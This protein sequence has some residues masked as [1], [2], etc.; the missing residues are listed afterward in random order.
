MFSRLIVFCALTA[1]LL[2]AADFEATYTE[3]G[4][5]SNTSRVRIKDGDVVMGDQ[6]ATL[7]YRSDTKDIVAIDHGQ[8][9]YLVFDEAT[10]ERM[11]QQMGDMQQ[12]M[13]AAMQQ[14][15]SQMSQMSEE[16]RAMMER[17][18]EQQ[19]MGAQPSGAPRISVQPAGK[20]RV[21]GMSCEKLRMSE[22]GRPASEACVVP[23]GAVDMSGADYEAL[24]TATDNMRSMVERM[25]G[26][27]TQLNGLDFRALDGVPVQVRDL[28]DGSVS[29]LTTHSNAE[30]D[31]SMFRVPEGY[32]Q[33]QMPQ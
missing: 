2:C 16:Q 10:A 14:L 6:R 23:P 18:L 7:L 19:G 26:G 25:T 20:A 15:Q 22:N 4:D 11:E 29:T 8:K 33:K 27:F 12:Q 5:S 21:G 3:Q 28:D 13:A 31:S 30:L 17:M 9:T 1:P 24:L 32:R